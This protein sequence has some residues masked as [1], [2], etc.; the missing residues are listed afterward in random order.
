MYV[1][2]IGS[3]D[4]YDYEYLKYKCDIL[5]SQSKSVTIISGGARGTDRL[6]ERYAAEK[7]LPI[8]VM[9]ADWASNGKAAG[10]IRNKLMLKVATHVIAFWDY[11]SPGTK[12]M[13]ESAKRLKKQTR[14]IC[15]QIKQACQMPK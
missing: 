13:I 1:A 7:N 11:Q 10:M 3:R 12:H 9:K 5:L 15:T 6:A 2:I 4:F 14:I 8:V